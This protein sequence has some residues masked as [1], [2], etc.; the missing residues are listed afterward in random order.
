MLDV[1]LVL[2]AF[3]AAAGCTGLGR[4]MG[5]GPAWR[6][7]DGQIQAGEVVSALLATLL[8]S[9]SGRGRPLLA[10]AWARP[11]PIAMRPAACPPPPD[12][13]PPVSR[14][15]AVRRLRLSARR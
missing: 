12:G 5:I 13:G 8:G 4:V 14:P 6:L 3:A 11:A 7:S 10:E 15:D 9:I 1:L 2:I